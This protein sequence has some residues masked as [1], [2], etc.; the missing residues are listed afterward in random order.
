MNIKRYLKVV[1]AIILVFCA[2]GA[3][4]G[5]AYFYYTPF[6][7]ESGNVELSQGTLDAK[8]KNRVNV[9]VLGTDNQNKLTDTIMICQ[10]DNEDDEINILSIPRDTKVTLNGR[11]HKINAAH[12]LGGVERAIKTVKELTGIPIHHFAVIHLSA[13]RDC[14][15]AL[16]GVD[17]DVPQNMYY[18]DPYQGLNINLKKGYQHLNGS[19]CEQL[20]RFRR[21]ARGDLQRVE[22][23][24]SFLR[25][26]AKQKFTL[27]NVAKIGDIYGIIEDNIVT[28][29]S[30]RDM[31]KIAVKLV[32]YKENVN[33]Y[34]AENT[35]SDPFVVLK[36]DYL[37]EM[38][39]KFGVEKPQE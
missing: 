16:G 36:E 12:A 6:G 10:V 19:Q 21:Y 32:D 17:F 24:Q 25:E 39:I 27:S 2:I 3:G 22:V 26:F 34:V 15:D 9:L 8:E 4:M 14:V 23:Q 37:K 7:T 28:D 29:M 13:L 38:R 5:L 31:K 30:L 33:T 20:I 35:L 1:S 18:Q 11:S